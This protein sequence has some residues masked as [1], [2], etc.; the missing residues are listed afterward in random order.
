[1]VDRARQ[2]AVRAR[3]IEYEVLGLSPSS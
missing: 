3:V 2:P 1:V